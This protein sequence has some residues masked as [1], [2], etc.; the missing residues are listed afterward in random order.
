MPEPLRA[1]A[2]NKAP[3]FQLLENVSTFVKTDFIER[4]RAEYPGEAVSDKRERQSGYGD[5]ARPQA[6][7]SSV[8]ARRSTARNAVTRSVSKCLTR[9]QTFGMSDI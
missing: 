9:C 8:P 5:L 4:G 6:A 3:D 1:Q 2:S 7:Q